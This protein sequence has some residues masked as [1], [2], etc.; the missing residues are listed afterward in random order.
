VLVPLGI[1]RWV[2][3]QKD[4]EWV[5][6][7]HYSTADQQEHAITDKDLIK[8][9]LAIHQHAVENPQ[10]ATNG[11]Q[12]TRI[13]FAYKLKNGQ[14]VQRQYYIDT[15]TVAAVTLEYVMS[16]PEIIFGSQFDTVDALANEIRYIDLYKN[17]MDEML[18][19]REQ[20]RSLMEAVWLDAKA[21]NLA[22]NWTLRQD[23]GEEA[24]LY[25]EGKDWQ[26]PEGYTTSYYWSI[27]YSPQST[28]TWAWLQA[29]YGK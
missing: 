29:Y 23:N 17:D 10:E 1:T 11:L 20:I 12:D 9:V 26:T 3:D 21:G 4:V 18:T 28:H 19:D 14:T 27:A 6:L 16:Q 24:Y 25:I 2:P 7:D 8:Q 5:S 13:H 15:G 22:Q